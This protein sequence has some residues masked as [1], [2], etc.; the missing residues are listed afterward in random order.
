MFPS[1]NNIITSTEFDYRYITDDDDDD[2]DDDKES[3]SAPSLS[4]QNSKE[5][6]RTEKRV[7]A[8]ETLF[9]R[10][11]QSRKVLEDELGTDRFLKVYRYIQVG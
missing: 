8:R 5:L 1:R 4:K 9:Q 3:Q 6:K 10:I 11:E 2:D 7:K